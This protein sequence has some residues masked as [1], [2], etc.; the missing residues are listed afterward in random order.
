M[1]NTKLVTPTEAARLIEAG[2]TLVLAGDETILR[3]C[4]RTHGLAAPRP[5]SSPLTAVSPIRLM[6]W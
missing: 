2:R 6:S 3:H 1:S 4:P 5:T